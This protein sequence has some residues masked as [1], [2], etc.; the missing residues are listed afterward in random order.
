MAPDRLLVALD[1][2]SLADAEGLL[3][4]LDGVVTGC[5]IGTQL[6]TAA[7][8]AAVEMARKRGFRVFLDLKFHDIPNTV[9]GATRE[10]ARLGVF[11]LDVHASG[12]VAMMRAAAEA[13]TRAA[14]DFAVPR[15]LVLGVTV[16]TSLDRTSLHREVGVPASVEAHVLHLAA[17]AREAGLDGCVASAH[18]ISPLRLAMGA[19]WIIVTPGIRISS[20]EGG[21][22]PPQDSAG[23]RADDQARVATPRQARAAGADYIVV[24]RP[25]TAAADPAA[26]AAAIL[27]EL[28]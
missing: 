25:I 4:R 18:E 2:E 21:S 17:I 6:F 8:P 1:V 5:K 23:S 9:A 19:G 14:Q 20:P 16:L 7:G 13:A 24:G 27:K 10:T 3:A 12:G 15:P 22:R 26:A 28:E 11:M